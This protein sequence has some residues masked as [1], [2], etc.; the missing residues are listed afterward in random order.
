MNFVHGNPNVAVCLGLAINKQPHLGVVYCPALD[1]MFTGRK[2]NGAFCNG[3]KLNV[4]CS[5]SLKDSLVCSE[6]GSDRQVE[7]RDCVFKNMQSVGWQCHGLRS[8]GSAAMNIMA[9]ASGHVNAYYEF[10]L[11]CWD[12][13]APCAILIEAGGYVCDTSGSEL[14][15]LKRRLIVACSK[16]IAQELSKALVVQL[17]LS[18]D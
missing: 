12:M 17:D 8:T 4:R 6:L 11:H 1:Q 15:L 13:C 18:S 5:S 7:K 16:N 2:G 10:G 3:N 14:D 9:V